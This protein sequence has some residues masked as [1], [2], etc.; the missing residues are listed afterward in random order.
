MLHT[1]QAQNHIND[2]VTIDIDNFWIAYDKITSTKDSSEKYQFL[3]RFFISKG[4]PGLKAMIAARSYTNKSYIDAIHTY[5]LYWNSIR[6]SMLKAKEYSKQINKN[7]GKLK[8]IYPSLK[9]AK[10]YFTV[11]A[12][13]SG[14]TTMDSLVLIGSEI[15]MA[16]H[17]TELKEFQSK[18][19][20]LASYLKTNPINI[21]VFTN[22][23]EYVHTQQKTTVSPNLLGQSILEGVAEFIAE[24]AT[25]KPSTT[26]AL[27]YGKKYKKR[28][29][30]V[31]CSAMFNASNGFW[32]YSNLENEFKQRDLGYYVGYAISEAYYNKS[33]NKALS[34][35]EMIE[36]DYNNKVDVINFAEQSG[37]FENSVIELEKKYEYSRPTVTAINPIG[38]DRLISGSVKRITINFSEPMD[39]KHRNFELGPLG[40]Q[41][42]LVIKNMLGFSEDGKTLTFE[43]EMDTNKRYQLVVG[44]GF[45]NTKGISLKPYLIDFNTI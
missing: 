18:L 3:D 38:E 39:K 22:I 13:R 23:H 12:F 28:I 45:R 32:L 6:K 1:S 4:T 37:Y 33:A 9:P 16:N 10:I 7:I 8:A 35:K 20:S 15:A 42:Q 5:P 21:L 19:P 11:G 40:K 34:I 2:I 17:H 31:F 14:G 26:P 36:L 24:K 30:E 41:N 25:G 44:E 27:N 43:V 29:V